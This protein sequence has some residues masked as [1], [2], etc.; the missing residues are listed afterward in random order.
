MKTL[1]ISTAITSLV[2][3]FGCACMQPR[4]DDESMN[5]LGKRL[6]DLTAVVDGTLR[7][8]PAGTAGLADQ[9]LVDRATADDPAL[10]DEFKPYKLIIT[11]AGSAFSVLVCTEDGAHAL[12]ED[13]SC[14]VKLDRKAWQQSPRPPCQPELQS[15]VVCKP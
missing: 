11:R 1:L 5:R 6:L 2:S 3:M 12:L 4:S 8:D 13:A 7:R 10:R 14:T 9:A 15:E